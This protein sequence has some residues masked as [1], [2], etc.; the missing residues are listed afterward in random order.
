[1]G[2]LEAYEES[3]SARSTYVD[4]KVVKD[5]AS[6]LLGQAPTNRAH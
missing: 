1:M 4:P 5:I 6:A 2:I 3:E